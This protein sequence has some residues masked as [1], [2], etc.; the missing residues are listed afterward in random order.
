MIIPSVSL[1]FRCGWYN[2]FKYSVLM[3]HRF[4]NVFQ[5]CLFSDC[6]LAALVVSLPR[7]SVHLDRYL[8]LHRPLDLR[9]AITRRTV[10]MWSTNEQRSMTSFVPP[11]ARSALRLQEHLK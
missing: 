5:L 2:V 1:L 9:S 4:S 10:Q 11:S 6:Y 3:F 7:L 8:R